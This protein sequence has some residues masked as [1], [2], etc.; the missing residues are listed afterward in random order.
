LIGVFFISVGYSANKTKVNSKMCYISGGFYTSLY[1]AKDEAKI[2]VKPFYMDVYPVT[3]AE[4]LVFVK[5]N[6]YWSRSKVKRIFAD[7]NY[8]INWKS[9]FELGENVNPGSP[10][11]N[12]SWFAAKAYAKWIGKRLPTVAEWE[13]VA[14]AS[15][16]KPNAGDDKNNI[17][18]IQQWYSKKSDSKL[19]SVG[20]TEKNFWGIYDMFGLVWEWQYDFNT[21]LVSGESRGDSNV[22]RNFFCGG[23]SLSAKDVTNY[24]AFMRYGFRSS[25]QAN[26]TCNNLGFRC[27]KDL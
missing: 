6:I 8:L 11:T 22:D 17:A 25:L 10:V 16:T 15:V 26:Y 9:D 24:P 18:R 7:N 19:D 5:A 13:F 27:V 23:G 12:V 4:Y 1:A 2:I 21:A 3:N 20:S 14:S